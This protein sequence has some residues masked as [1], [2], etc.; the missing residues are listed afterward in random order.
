M[1]PG[2]VE[3]ILRSSSVESWRAW[4]LTVLGFVYLCPPAQLANSVERLLF[5][6]GVVWG[7]QCGR[8]V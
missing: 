2:A 4:R 7:G 3:S 8:A 1:G 5:K 6:I